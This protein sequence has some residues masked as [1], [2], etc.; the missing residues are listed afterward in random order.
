M[1]SIV[2]RFGEAS[3]SASLADVSSG[4]RRQHGEPD[5][6]LAFV[7]SADEWVDDLARAWPESVRFGCETVTQFADDRL[8]NTGTAQLF[9]FSDSGSRVDIEV[10]EASSLNPPETAEIERAAR[11]LST[12][13][14]AFLVTDGLRFPFHRLLDEL[15]GRVE[16]MPV[17]GGLA[18]QS[19]PIRAD[20]A[21]VFFGEKIYPSACLV[22]RWIGVV[23]WIEIVRG[24]NPASPVYTV[25]RADG[26]TLFEIDGVPATEWFRS[27]FTVDGELAPLP[28]SAHRFP[29]IIEGPA[30][31]RK[32]LYRSMRL[33]DDPPGAV[34][35]WADFRDGDEIRLGMGNDSSLVATATRLVARHQA[36]AAVLFSCVGREQVLGPRAAEEVE[37]IHGALHDLPL[38]GFF[39]FGE[40][41]PTSEGR[42]AFYNQTA[43]LVLLHESIND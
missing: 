10:V 19:L 31:H 43:I 11:F 15:Q 12:G 22:A 23:A 24:W 18:S 2:L 30:R 14:A 29:V 1:R 9:W 3:D 21:R 5:V 6:V 36:E 7:P 28:E 34:T 40:I 4:I 38:S 33:F 8:V 13:D 35:F 41:G 20:G 16:D 42:L 27:F 26:N 17:A 25:T 32:G 37:A 39:T